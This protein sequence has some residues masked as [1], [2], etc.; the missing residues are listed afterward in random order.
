MLAFRTQQSPPSNL[1]LALLVSSLQKPLPTNAALSQPGTKKENNVLCQISNRKTIAI[2]KIK[3]IS[4]ESRVDFYG[5]E[6]GEKSK[7]LVLNFELKIGEL[8]KF[9]SVTM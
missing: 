8:A 2:A 5:N 9:D 3:H 1:Q 7:L 6:L 4:Y